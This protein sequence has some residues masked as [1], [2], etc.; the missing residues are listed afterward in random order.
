MPDD[1]LDGGDAILQACRDLGID[2]I[3]SSPGSDWGSVWEALARQEAGRVAGPAYLGC[4]HELLAVDVALGYTA[5]TGRMQAVLLHAG[6]GLMYGSMGLYGARVSETPML[7][8]S[9]EST[10]F[11]DREDFDPGPQWYNNHNAAGGMP[12]IVQPL[13]KWAHQAGSATSLYE[14]VVRAGELACAGPAGPAY[15]DV[16]LEVMR[17]KW[18]APAESRRVPPMPRLQPS[19]SDLDRVAA[20]LRSAVNPVVVTASAGRTPEGYEALVGLAELL[21]LPIVESPSGEVNSFPK[22]HPLHLGFDVNPLLRDSD[23]VLVVKARTPWYPPN[24]GPGR[25]KVVVVDEHPFKTHMA[26]Q[27]LRADAFLSG[28]V[29]TTLRLLGD[30]VR[31]GGAGAPG[32]ARVEERGARVKAAHEA[33]QQR[34]H[35]ALARARA[36]PGVHPIALAAALGE[37][38]PSDTIYIDETTVH[39]ILN[40]RHLAHRGSLTYLSVRAG[41]G[42]GLGVALGAKL[43]RRDRPVVALLGDGAFLYNPTLPCLG[44]ARDENL[45]ILIVIYNNRGYR[46]MRDSQLAFYPDGA[47]RTGRS[48]GEAISGFDYEEV[49]NHFGGFGLRVEAA[50]ELP[51]ALRQ[52]HAAVMGGRTAIVNVVLGE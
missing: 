1:V 6:V 3:V 18:I 2:Y 19:L 4:S 32:A 21:C 31:A 44:F 13:V 28:D 50:A 42:Q 29:P 47:A 27:N 9:G 23:L 38:L 48:H 24:R 12:A 25:A 14:M 5:M 15:L 51:S 10:S 49:A 30:A 22:D 16:P 41:L 52:A 11:G 40:R 43:A 46:A 34:Y 8:M 36:R 39:L 37:A 17:A 35:S 20:M 33:L 45:P 7:V 26:Y